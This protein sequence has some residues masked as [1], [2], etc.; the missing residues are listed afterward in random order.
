MLYSCLAG[1]LVAASVLSAAPAAASVLSAAA[2]PA[3]AA[4]PPVVTGTVATGAARSLG[5]PVAAQDP[6][7]SA[8]VATSF[9]P[10]GAR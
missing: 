10:A 9:G 1:L 6:A 5:E 3:A 7:V 4:A 2:V 8:V